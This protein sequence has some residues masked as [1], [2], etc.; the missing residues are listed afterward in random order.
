MTNKEI[1]KALNLTGKLMELHEG[2]PFKIKS[3][4][5]AAFRIERYPQQIEHIEST[6]LENIQGV[7]KSLHGKITE[8]LEKGTT[9]EL[10]SLIADTP[11]GVME[12]LGIKGIGAKK[13]RLIWKEMGIESV[14]ELLYA[15]NENRLVEMKGF[16]QK[17]QDQIIQSIQ[18]IQSNAGKYHYAK[19]ESLALDMLEVVKGISGVEKA[20][21]TGQ[22]RRK[23][24]VIDNIEILAAGNIDLKTA[25][26]TIGEKLQ[27][28][29]A[30]VEVK[31]SSIIFKVNSAITCGLTTCESSAY[32]YTLYNTTG[33]EAHLEL[34]GKV[35]ESETEESIYKSAGW[36]YIIPELREGRFEEKYKDVDPANYITWE[37]IKGTLHN[38]STYSDGA[39]TV[40]EMA[41]QCI[42]LGLQ[43]LG[44]NDHSQYAF[45]AN[46][47]PPERVMEQH[48]EIDALNEK[49]KPFKIFKGIEADILPDGSL[50]YDETVWKSFDFI[51][52]SVHAVLKMDEDKANKRIIK[53]IENPYT[54]ILG[55]PTGRLLLSRPGYPIDHKL[56]IDACAA[57]DVIL[58][59]NANP[60]RLDIDW[61]WIPYAMD[62]GVMISINPDAHKRE[63]FVDMQ[64][65][66]HVARKGGLTKDMTF[67]ALSLEEMEKYFEDRKKK[68]G[69]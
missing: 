34:I 11:I 42:E 25:V 27:L 65:G 36:P 23:A 10:S 43:Y 62:K 38:H 5:N 16:G 45:Y 1:G 63:T 13:I 64:Y 3:Y 30:N 29:I 55:H 14:G 18:Y 6:E 59:L 41:K 22:M 54:T 31:D 19:V 24:Q 51:V 57:N 58:E 35:S 17:T 56:I 44:M 15:C 21:L 26:S 32:A 28:D 53:A 47:L 8:L 9:E 66:V 7:G 68:K 2:N 12:M 61:E 46:G 50:D 33:N 4:Q 39:N 40:E 52:A 67:N 37:D 60:F 69:L 48:K 20:E 49:L